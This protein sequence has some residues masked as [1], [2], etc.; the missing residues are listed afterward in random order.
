M[1][2][3]RFAEVLH[4]NKSSIPSTVLTKEEHRAFTNFWRDA[5]G[6][7]KNNGEKGANASLE[8]VIK[9][10]QEIYKDYPEFL[11]ALENFFRNL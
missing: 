3:K 2:E 10:A 5:I 6:Y 4:V 9:S 11:E 1:I 7:I 8:K